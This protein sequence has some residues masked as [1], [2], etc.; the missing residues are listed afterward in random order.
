MGSCSTRARS[1]GGP[2]FAGS[3]KILSY[4]RCATVYSFEEK[5]EASLT[6]MLR[7][8]LSPNSAFVICSAMHDVADNM[9]V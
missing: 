7:R 1:F 3:G 5:Q 8:H 9:A 6:K 2:Q 4:V